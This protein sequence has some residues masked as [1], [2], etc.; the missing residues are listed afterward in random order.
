MPE[1]TEDPGWINGA[2]SLQELW[3][4]RFDWI[5]DAAR[6]R[7]FVKR[8]IREGDFLVAYDAARETVEERQSADPWMQQQMA[9]ALAQLGS[10]ARAQAIL[11]TLVNKDPTNRE[12]LALLARTYKDQWCTD[13]SNAAALNSAFEWYKRAFEIDP[14]D[15]YPGINAASLALLRHD[16]TT[17]HRLAGEVLEI[18]KRKLAA[19]DPN[20]IYWL[21]VTLAE[22]LVILR[23]RADAKKAYRSAAATP[24]LSLRELSS[25]RRQARLLSKHLYRNSH[26]FDTCFPIP[27]LVVFSGHMLD[28]AGRSVPRFPASKE[29]SIRLAINKQLESIGAGIGF[30]SAACGSDIIF[31]EAMLDRGAN[32]H[33]V[34]PWPKE[35]FIQTSVAITKD[36]NWIARFEDVLR[37]AASV[38]VLGQLHVPGS[39]IGFDYCNSVMVGLAR[40]YARSLNLELVPLAAWDGLPGEPGGTGSFVRYWRAHHVP[41]KIIPMHFRVPPRTSRTKR[42]SDFGQDI[43]DDLEKWMRATSRQE[44]K[45]IL[46]ADVTSYAQ[47]TEK[48]LPKFIGQFSQRIS[49]LVAESA[50]APTNVNTWGDAFF[51]VFNRVEHAGRFALELRDLVKTTNWADLGLPPELSI[52][53]AVHA[54]PIFVTFDPVSRQM[55]FTG[56]HVVRAARIEPV[57]HA[58]EVFASEEFAALAAAEDA[59][60]FSC[61]FVGTTQ[62]AKSYGSFRIYSLV[63]SQNTVALKL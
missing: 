42:V 8:A 27:K 30:S 31:L 57:A 28:T 61:D 38:R 15:Y 43:D 21:R 5:Q 24:D 18:C 32:V 9:L 46:F 59:Q 10:T 34:L 58:G 11:M 29:R 19:P 35:E 41:V 37:R 47:L 16:H 14:P 3:Q 55:T 54:G 45:A 22:A 60:E 4:R 39:A 48:D 63:R 36:D 1:A 51:F 12:T 33:V 20:E 50:L 2:T 49:R 13:T 40:L 62:L 25:T 7:A 26:V 44:I 6:T 52:R 56:A 53:I 23:R 17:A